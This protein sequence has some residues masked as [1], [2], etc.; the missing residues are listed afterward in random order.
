MISMFIALALSFAIVAAIAPKTIQFLRK[1]KFGQSI[2]EIGPSWHKTKQGTPTM[3]GIMFIFATIVIMV[4]F[5]R[6][7][8]VIVS[9]IMAV[10]YGIIGFIDDYVKVVKKQNKGLSAKHKLILQFVVAGAYLWSLNIIGAISTFIYIPFVNYSINFG[11]FY[12]IFSLVFIVGFVNSVNLTDGVDG[13]AAGVS[14]PVF[15]FFAVVSIM[16]SMDQVGIYACALIGGCLGFLVYNFY[17]AKVFMGDTGSLFLGGAICS[18][19][20]V[21]DMPL[22]III[23]GLVFLLEALSVILQVTFFKLTKKRIF[24]MSPIHHH[25]EMS[26]WSEVRIVYLFSMITVLLCIASFFGVSAWYVI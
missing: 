6:D 17:P 11:W 8:R 12:Y 5:C 16:Y 1:L 18:L 15:I 2:L 24:K 25:F 21:L 19:A 7:L 13:L 14:A 20:Y 9:F 4:L 3:G 23:A 26:G 10:C 22:I